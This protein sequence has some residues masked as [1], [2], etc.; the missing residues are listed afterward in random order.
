MLTTQIRSDLVAHT[1][2]QYLESTVATRINRR[3]GIENSI[4]CKISVTVTIV[5]V[6]TTT[7]WAISWR[8]H[9]PVSWPCRFSSHAELLSSWRY[10]LSVFPVCFS[11]AIAASSL[12]RSTF[13]RCFFSA[14]VAVS[15]TSL[16]AQHCPS[17]SHLL[18]SEAL[19]S[20]APSESFRSPAA[21]QPLPH[22]TVHPLSSSLSSSALYSFCQSR[23]HRFFSAFLSNCLRW[24]RICWTPFCRAFLSHSLRTSRR[25]FCCAHQLNVLCWLV[26]VYRLFVAGAASL[27][28]SCVS[29][30]SSRRCHQQHLHLASTS[31]LHSQHKTWITA[32]QVFLL[33]I[34]ETF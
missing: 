5:Q 32:K 2:T 29:V 18:P 20:T 30:V 31:S 23:H 7:T 22:A 16:A 10:F 9:D 14:A 27:C 28:S 6:Q 24:N 25:T 17:T 21:C 11:S 33:H 4:S 34:A 8:R 26:S 12:V 19:T 1:H 13:V 3:F 15:S